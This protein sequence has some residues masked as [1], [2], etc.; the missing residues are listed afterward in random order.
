MN[1]R[2]F[3]HTAGLAATASLV[4]PA[5]VHAA[6]ESA[7]RKRAIKKAIMYGT[8]GG[9]KGSVREKFRMIKEAGFAGVEAMGGMDHEKVLAAQKETGLKIPSVCCHTHWAKPVSDPNPEVRKVGLEG[10]KT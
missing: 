1:R 7:G 4:A 5:T 8:L 6:E 2:R 10:L 9:L 3:I